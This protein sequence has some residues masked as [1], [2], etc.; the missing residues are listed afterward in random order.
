M[1]KR[2]ALILA[3]VLALCLCACNQA[4]TAQENASVAAEFTFP[5]GSAVLGVNISGLTRSNAW[6]AFEKAVGEYTVQLSVDG[7]EAIFTAQDLGLTCSKERFEAIMDAC[8]AGAEV[9]T[10]GLIVLNEGKLRA[11]LNKNFNKPVTEASLAFDEA[12]GSFVLI[13]DAIGQ[14]SNPNELLDSVRASILNLEAQ[15]TL[16]DVS[17][18]IQPTIL[19]ED[20]AAIQA[21]E[22]VNAMNAV[23]LTYT[24]TAE[25]KTS[26]HEIPADILR[27]FIS[28]GQNG[29]TPDI[30][31]HAL[32]SYVAELSETYSAASTQGNFRTTGGGTVGLTVSYNGVYVDQEALVEDIATCILEGTSGTRTA[33]FQSSG[34]RD[35]PYGGTYIEVNL[36]AQRL[37]FYKYGECILSTS[38]VSG[39]VSAGWYTPNGVFSIYAKEAGTYL[40]GEDYRTFVNYWMPFYG[41]YGLHD[42]TWRGSFGGDIYV[43]GGS[44]GCV[45]LPLSSAATIFN[46]APVGTKVIVYGGRRSAPPQAQSLGGTTSYNVADDAGTITLNISPRFGSPKMSYSSSNSSVA[47]VSNGG[48]V[49]INGVGSA[50]ITVSVPASGGYTS[51]TTSVSITVHSACEDGRHKLGTPT[52]V[53]P[54]TCQPGKEKVSC[55]KCSFSTEQEIP[56][57]DKH[58]YSAW[59]IATAAT[60]GAK[61]SEERTCTTCNL[62]KETRDIPATGNHTPGS[63]VT[64]KEPNC[65][66]TGK[67]ETRCTVCGAVTATGELPVVPGAHVPGELK[68]VNP[69]CEEPGY[70]HQKCSKCNVDLV[71]ETLQPTGHSMK[72][73][74]VNPTCTAPGYTSVYCTN[75]RYLESLVDIPATGH[76]YTTQTVNPTCTSDGYTKE[77]C[78][79]CGTVASNTVHGA[80]GHSFSGGTCSHCGAADPNYQ[81][82]QTEP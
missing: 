23:A 20:E 69:T 73:E 2:F 6:T 60:C 11:L 13:P 25:D 74:T 82:P 31:R 9:D 47:S 21:L 5:E 78:T 3:L 10:A 22:K 61:G 4:P 53:T 12:S 39:K 79:N 15:Q 32:E 77:Y 16:T 28:L 17:Q 81:A 1:K 54:A 50:T 58:T 45:N 19:D 43:Y 18:I 36:D 26:T 76:S 52:T 66:E 57:K 70:K 51:A 67:T 27:T 35:M 64:V 33:P 68:V 80:T 29:V 46:N 42:A 7:A 48:V 40:V 63:P 62:A 71:K 14:I 37:Y 41:G 44:H 38:F 55:T 65:S 24:F 30:N 8:A 72:T 75:C 59:T 56:A 49:T 34:I